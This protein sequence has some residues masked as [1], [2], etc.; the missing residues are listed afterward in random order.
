MT[1]PLPSPSA[2]ATEHARLKRERDDHI[3]QARVISTQL[4]QIELHAAIAGVVLDGQGRPSEV[5]S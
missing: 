2:L 1:A 3:Q 5:G 4:A